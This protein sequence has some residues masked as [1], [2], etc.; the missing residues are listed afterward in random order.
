MKR[1]TRMALITVRRTVRR[2]ADIVKY[3]TKTAVCSMVPSLIDDVTLH[4]ASLSMNE[5]QNVVTDVLVA[6]AIGVALKVFI[7]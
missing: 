1:C 7:H 3:A 4:H 5:I 2:R 6:N